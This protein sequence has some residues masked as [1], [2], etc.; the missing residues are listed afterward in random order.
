MTPEASAGFFS[1][2]LFSWV[3]PLLSLGYARPLE[4]PD[5]Y[6]LQDQ[7]ASIRIAN[8]V[9]ESFKRRR[10]EAQEYNARLEGGKVKP[11][12]RAIWWAVRGNRAAREKTWRE[13]DGKH[14]ASLILAMNDSI[15]WFFWSGGVLKVIAD[16]A[17]VTSPLVVKSIITFVANSYTSH[18]IGQRPPSVGFGIGLAFVLLVLQLISSWCMNHFFYRSMASGVLL[19]G[20][21]ITAIYSRSL[22]LTSRSRA[23]LSNGR[24]VNHISTDVSR[25]DY[26][27]GY[28]HMVWTAPIQL[29]ICLILLLINLGPSAL[30]GF[31][32]FI[33]VTPINTY[34]V[35]RLFSFRLKSMQWTDKRSKS[36]QEMLGGMKIIKFFAWEVPFLKRISEF[37]HL[38]MGYIRTLLVLRA[39]MNAA[40]LSLPALASVVAFITYSLLGHSLDAATIFTSLTLFQLL[41]LPL[42]LL[43]MSISTISDAATA[44]ERLYDVFVAETSDETLVHN[45]GLDFA[46]TVRNASFSWD[47]PPPQLEGSKKLKGGKRAKLGGQGTSKPSAP[48]QQKQVDKANVFQIKDVNL[49]IP[50]GQLVAIVGAVGMGKTSLLQGLTG[51]MRR[52]AGSVEF[53]GT[54]SYCAQSAWIQ[55]ATI[56]DNICFG[57]PFEEKRYWKAIRDACLEADLQ[58]LPNY[59]LTEVG[60]KGISLSGG[61]K[62]RINICRAIY[63]NTDI[64]I[65]DDPL[66]ALDAHVGKDVFYNVLKSNDDRKTR[67]LVTHALHFLPEVDYIYTIVDG[68]IAESGTHHELMANEGAFARF[69]RE[70]GSKEGPSKKSEEA[71]ESHSEEPEKKDVVK[72]KGMMQEEERNTGAVRWQIYQQYLS[73][74]HGLIFV[75]SLLLSLVLMQGANVMSAYWLVYWEEMKWNYPQGFYM[76][77][78]AALGVSQAFTM[79]FVGF[80]FALLTYYASQNLHERA[81]YRV[82]HAPMS[83]FET[84]PLGRIMNRFAKD[85][86]SIDNLIGDA[87][88]MLSATT[89]QILGAIILISVVLPW[90][91]IV[92]FVV[93]VIYCYVAIFYR[94]SARELKDLC[95]VCTDP[96]PDAILRGSLYAHFSE[97]LS[98]LTT[99]RAYGEVDRFKNENHELVDI[100]NRAYW[101]T[102]TNQRWLGIRLDLL[103]VTLTF[104]VALLAVGT[105]FS[106]SPGQTGVVLSYVLGVQQSFAW[107]VRQFADVENNMNSVER[108]VHYADEVDQE[109]PHDVDNVTIPENWPSEGRI[110]MNDVVMKYRP[111]LPP[112]LKGLNMTIIPREKIGI[113]GRT[114]AGKSSVMTALFRIV[115]LSS[116][117]VGIDGVNIADVGL[118]RLRKSL[119]IIPQD[120]FLFSGTFRTNLDPFG[121]HDDA[122]LWDALKRAYL[123]DSSRELQSNPTQVE[124]SNDTLAHGTRFTLDSPIDEDGSNLSIGQRSLVSLARALVND[125]KILIL[126]EA[127]ASVDYE[128]DRKIQDTIATEFRDRTILCIAHRLRTIISYDRICVLDAGTIAEFDTPVNLYSIPNGIFRGMCDRSSI[129]FG[130]LTSASTRALRSR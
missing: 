85:I 130:D 107:A 54:V 122:R 113:V 91:S 7:H 70:F 105:R 9:L 38:E 26:C 41:R 46:L 43:P 19:R 37:R 82:L 32:L 71:K 62:Q 63:C 66:S 4:A 33:V 115:E 56:R 67:I 111:E 118:S 92:V 68:Q 119:S 80:V 102:V 94:A 48:A 101:L 51:E 127:T 96:I 110:V 10:K 78:Y 22:N 13:R 20:G 100:E 114:G 24:L 72:G 61:Q 89:S 31:A 14:K 128:T 69:V 95:K 55:N 108:V 123:V 36:I 47:S 21:L 23:T 45:Q 44:C 84:T 87:L 116:G 75:P 12:L 34:T 98:G 11:G 16:I 64:Q 8:L 59:D 42:M 3:T 77:I 5:L 74:G 109:A 117:S 2:L 103:G 93:L 28:F 60:E 6:K 49:E 88:R 79:F 65:F 112:V 104:T 29:T 83:F 27:M 25:I 99:I 90:F 17:Q 50:R 73:A 53:G 97:T 18:S 76:G 106:I 86:D 15:K 129:S 40:A 121:L 57:R 35:K 125:T 81:I 120:A 1:L 126:D 52:T 58:I 124:R 39:A 30:A